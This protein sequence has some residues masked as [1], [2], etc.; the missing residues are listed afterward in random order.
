M[1]V[2]RRQL[3][4]LE[5]SAGLMRLRYQAAQ[6][7]ALIVPDPMTTLMPFLSDADHRR[8]RRV[9]GV[10]VVLSA[11]AGLVSLQ[12]G[13]PVAMLA[14]LI[15]GALI[16]PVGYAMHL[17]RARLHAFGRRRVALA[18][19][20]GAVGVVPCAAIVEALIGLGRTGTAGSLGT[21]LVEEVLKAVAVVWL[22]GRTRQRRRADGLVVGAT[23]GMGFALGETLLFALAFADRPSELLMT[24]GVASFAAPVAHATWTAIVGTALCGPVT[25]RRASRLGVV[26]A[27][28]LAAILHSLWALQLP[29][30]GWLI[31]WPVAVSL[32]SILVLRAVVHQ[33]KMRS[34][35]AA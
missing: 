30:E 14:A 4:A 17:S 3:M 9:F 2:G 25:G 21:A 33:T 32:L 26:A 24:L 23:V 27:L 28:T 8:Y 11:L 19:A 5:P 20:V 15:I 10:A 7:Q 18:L 1:I 12:T 31:A 6:R 34:P 13:A 35:R 22:L 16:H 29:L